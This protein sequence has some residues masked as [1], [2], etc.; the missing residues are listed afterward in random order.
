MATPTLARPA[1]SSTDRSAPDSWFTDYPAGGRRELACV[2][3]RLDGDLFDEFVGGQA[4]LSAGA[5]EILL[6]ALGK[7]VARTLGSGLLRVDVAA[8]DAA[9][10][11]IVLVCDG[12]RGVP[13]AEAVAATRHALAAATDSGVAGADIAFR[14][15]SGDAAPAGEHAL[16]LRLRDSAGALAV[17]W[18]YDAPR[19]DRSTIEELS[20]QFALALIDVTSG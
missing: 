4:Q 1:A 14:Y 16:S 11:Q 17:E 3:A 2:P 18:W 10:A 12:H 7:A 5:E 13:G 20:D 8:M 9:P 19:F 6:A 15:G